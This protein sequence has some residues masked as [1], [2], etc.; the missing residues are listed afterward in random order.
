MCPMCW[1]AALAAFAVLFALSAA[2]VAGTD[3]VSLTLAAVAGLT[4]SLQ[5]WGDNVFVPWWWYAIVCG[6]LALRIGYL[7][8]VDRRRLLVARV[9]NQARCYAAGRCPNKLAV[10]TAH[11]AQEEDS[12]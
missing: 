7:I 1:A 12:R 8:V 6:A 5:R 10:E 11:G 9:W 2:V 4:G 3:G